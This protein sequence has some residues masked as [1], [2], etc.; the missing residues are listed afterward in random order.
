MKY[1]R[2]TNKTFVPGSVIG[3]YQE[4]GEM[5]TPAAMQEDPMQ[6]MLMMAEQAL[7]NQDCESDMVVCQMLIE[8]A[9]SG[10]GAPQEG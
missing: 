8:L 5:G 9:M 2:K 6:Q 3:F 4:G 1:Q 10:A 7:G